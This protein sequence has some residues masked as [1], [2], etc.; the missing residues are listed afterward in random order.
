MTE[1]F[2]PDDLLQ[3]RS[4]TALTVG[5]AGA[6][7]LVEKPDEAKDRN[8]ARIWLVPLDGSEPRSFTAGQDSAPK[9]SPD[10]TRLAFVSNRCNGLQVHIIDEAGGE[11]NAVTHLKSGV[12]T[13][14]WSPDGTRLLLTAMQDV[15]P[16][17]K[18]ERRPPPSGKVPHVV[19]RLPYKTDGIGYT[20]DH[21]IHLFVAATDGG[22]AVQL[23]DGPFDVRSARFSPDGA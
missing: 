21:E 9:W 8:D 22:D 4:I 1:P 13:V 11:A 20:L 10:G 12:S 7:C 18:G 6:A 5:K 2:R 14:D 19:W 15:D 17:A 3:Y 16:S 23:T